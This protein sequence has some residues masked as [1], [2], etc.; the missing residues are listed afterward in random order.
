MWVRPIGKAT[1]WKRY[2][3]DWHE[4]TYS[5]LQKTEVKRNTIVIRV[6]DVVLATFHCYQV[7]RT[8]GS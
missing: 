1:V 7:Y 4:S 2:G 3:G 6:Q 8:F 5:Q